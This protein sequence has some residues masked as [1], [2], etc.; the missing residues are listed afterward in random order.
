MKILNFYTYVYENVK[1][2]NF[3]LPQLPILYI[4]INYVTI[5][6]YCNNRIYNL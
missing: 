2:Q 5:F 4:Y 3:H 6:F 1:F